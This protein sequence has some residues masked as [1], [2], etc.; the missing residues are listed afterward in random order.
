MKRVVLHSLTLVVFSAAL[1]GAARSGHASPLPAAADSTKILNDINSDDLCQNW[2]HSWEEQQPADKDQVYRPAAFKKFPPSRFRME[3][4]FSRSG[5]CEWLYLAPDDNHRFKSGKW[6]LDSK[7]KTLLRITTEGTTNSY[8]ITKLNKQ[9][10]R[11]VA[12]EPK[13]KK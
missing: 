13:T 5:D 9:L 10:L 6:Q 8:R 12:I 4:K 11:L 7:D 1:C 2:V 3:Y